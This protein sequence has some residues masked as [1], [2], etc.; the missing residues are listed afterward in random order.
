MVGRCHRHTSEG[1]TTFVHMAS[2]PG[3][4]SQ[5]TGARGPRSASTRE[6]LMAA[7]AELIAELGWGRV[8]TRAVAERAGL[9]HGPVSY[10]FRGQQALPAEAALH[11]F[12]HR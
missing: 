12:Q 3:Q 2:S 5:P 6:Q 7:A 8:T 1:S 4:S 10:H 11:A 9:P